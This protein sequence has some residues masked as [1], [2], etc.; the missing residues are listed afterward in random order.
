[1]VV[2]SAQFDEILSRV[3]QL[4]QERM[5]SKFVDCVYQA[6]DERAGSFDDISR[7]EILKRVCSVFGRRGGQKTQAN[8][9]RKLKLNLLPKG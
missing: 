7:Q 6:I 8:R 5:E 2:T 9:R 3:R 4:R 1:M